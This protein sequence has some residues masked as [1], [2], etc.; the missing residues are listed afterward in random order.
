MVAKPFNV[1]YLIH[2]IATHLDDD[3][4]VSSTTSQLENLL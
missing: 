2:R 4:G 1:E 3:D